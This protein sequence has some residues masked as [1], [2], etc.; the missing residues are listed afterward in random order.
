MAGPVEVEAKESRISRFLARRWA[1]PAV[2]AGAVAIFTLAC[3]TPDL[4][5]KWQLARE[6]DRVRARG[7]P[8]TLAELSPEMPPDDENAAVL[9]AKVL[10]TEPPEFMDFLFEG[11]EEHRAGGEKALALSRQAMKTV[12][13]ALS[14][15]RCDFGLD[16]TKGANLLLPHLAKLRAFARLF[17][18][19][20]ILNALD[21]K[22]AEAA[23]SVRQILLLARAL[24]EEPI[25]ISR[26]VSIAISGIGMNAIKEVEAMG[27]LGDEERRLLVGLIASLDFEKSATEALISERAFMVEGSDNLPA[28]WP[29]PAPAGNFITRWLAS[30][31][32]T[33]SPGER[34]RIMRLMTE[35]VEAS[36]LPTWEALPIVDDRAIRAMEVHPAFDMD[37]GVFSTGWV[38]ARFAQAM[39]HRDVCVLGLLC[40]LFRSGRGRYPATLDELAPEFLKDV[41][42]DPFTGKPFRYELRDDGRAFIVY[43]LGDNLKD[44]GGVER[45]CEKARECDDIAWEGRARGEAPAE[46]APASRERAEG[47]R[48]T[49]P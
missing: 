47:I 41:P 40:E 9:L 25:L 39:A 8:A 43:S 36:R 2:I 5:A 42:P 4:V 44:D 38:Y 7:E 26:L 34:L 37:D 23:D 17:K 33:P 22:R 1:V 14:R 21:G 3:L 49:T 10:P 48:E 19:E 32:R 24:D 46:Q 27:A 12:R 18:A 35:A 20:A 6:R 45:D 15:P 13:E 31:R 29:A 28:T 16:Y 30:R 11:H